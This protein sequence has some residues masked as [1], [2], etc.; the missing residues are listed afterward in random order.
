MM[1]KSVTQVGGDDNEKQIIIERKYKKN[2]LLVCKILIL[3]GLTVAPCVG[4]VTI[5]FFTNLLKSHYH[6]RQETKVSKKDN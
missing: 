1:M 5:R 6:C 3:L 2:R 4:T